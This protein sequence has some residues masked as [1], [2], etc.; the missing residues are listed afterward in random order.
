MIRKK[1]L[2]AGSNGFIG[3]FLLRSLKE[4]FKLVSLSLSKSSK[5]KMSFNVDL[6]KINNIESIVDKLPHCDILIFLVGLAHKKG[7]GKEIKIFRKINKNTLINLLQTLENSKKTPEKIIFAS[8]ISVYGEKFDQSTYEESLKEHPISPYA[9]TKHEAE[10]FLLKKYK[11]KSW[12]LRFAPVYSEKFKLNIKRRTSVLGQYYRVGSGENKL[13]L[14][15][16]KNID[17]A[18]QA[19]MRGEVPCGIYNIS[20]KKDYSYND[21]LE[22]V[23]AKNIRI[24]PTIFIKIIHFIGSI[25]KNIFLIENTVK[26]MSSN[27]FPSNKIRKFI[28]FPNLLN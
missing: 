12:I 7:K 8:T 11:K 20:D 24:V 15:N 22:Y 6:S 1:I 14:C 9:I 27:I 25:F 26:L 21:L 10:N 16:L 3:S 19:I 4:N 18:L 17:L 2:I 23:D 13:S 5:E 28:K